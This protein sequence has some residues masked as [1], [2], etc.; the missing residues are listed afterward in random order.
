MTTS[1]SIQTQECIVGI[2]YWLI[3][4]PYSGAL[5]DILRPRQSS[6]PLSS[7]CALWW[8]GLGLYEFSC[9]AG[10]TG[11]SIPEGERI[12]NRRLISHRFLFP[13]LWWVGRALSCDETRPAAVHSFITHSF[14][15]PVCVEV[16]PISDT[17]H[18]W[19]FHFILEKWL[20]AT[21]MEQQG[22]ETHS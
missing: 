16:D 15:R 8:A 21:Q 7:A 3:F 13:F 1:R 17:E 22:I 20:C 5:W 18:V 12:F 4:G 9:G 10:S 14:S 19:L 11:L 2:L 6:E